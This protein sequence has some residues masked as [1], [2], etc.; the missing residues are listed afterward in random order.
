[1]CLISLEYQHKDIVYQN[2]KEESYKYT[3]FLKELVSNTY[4]K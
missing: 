4:L 1:M 3:L 2:Q